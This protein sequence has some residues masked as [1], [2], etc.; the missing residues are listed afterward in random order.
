MFSFH[1]IGRLAVRFTSDKMAAVTTITKFINLFMRSLLICRILGIRI[2]GG[3]GWL[4][5][6]E[7]EIEYYKTYS[8]EL[9]D[10][11]L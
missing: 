3:E 2:K 10:Y 5:N 9:N 11:N 8:M 4:Y 1:S 6:R 7:R